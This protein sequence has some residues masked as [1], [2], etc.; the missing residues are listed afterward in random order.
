MFTFTCCIL[1]TCSC[2]VR[3]QVRVALDPRWTE[4]V[5]MFL[6][7]SDKVEMS[8]V[9]NCC[10]WVIVVVIYGESR[11]SMCNTPIITFIKLMIEIESS[12]LYSTFWIRVEVTRNVEGLFSFII[13]MFCKM[14]SLENCLK[15][16][17]IHLRVH[18]LLSL[19]RSLTDRWI[20]YCRFISE[21][22]SEVALW[23]L[24][25]VI[26]EDFIRSFERL[27]T[28]LS[29]VSNKVVL[30]FFLKIARGD[31]LVVYNRGHTSSTSRKRWRSHASA[32]TSE[33]C[34]ECSTIVCLIR[35]FIIR[36]FNF[37]DLFNHF[38][39]F[40]TILSCECVRLLD[41]SSRP[42]CVYSL[43]F[44]GIRMKLY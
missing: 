17:K 34:P 1:D 14:I 20:E 21:S 4:W 3:T 33:V 44:W 41:G 25:D 18:I 31:W 12:T 24:L 40:D 27:W 19:L 30:L 15:V 8:W 5:L 26:Q 36:L 35:T 23:M 10:N 29:T 38:R 42:V 39:L 6:L 2:F 7:W 32:S 28:S 43:R 13:L 37:N 16:F 22:A 11:R 9:V